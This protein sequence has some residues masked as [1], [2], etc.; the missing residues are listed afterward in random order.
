[1]RMAQPSYA[2]GVLAPSLRSR[3]DLAKWQIGLAEANNMLVHVHGGI[4]NR[5]GTQYV[6]TSLG[7]NRKIPFE[8][9]LDQSY[10]LEFSE[11]KLKIMRD[12]AYLMTSVIDGLEFEAAA[13]YIESPFKN[14]IH[15]PFVRTLS[16][17]IFEYAAPSGNCDIG[18]TGIRLT[19]AGDLYLKTDYSTSSYAYDS[20]INLVVG[21]SYEITLRVYM[22]DAGYAYKHTDFRLTCK[23]LGTGA[24]STMVWVNKA[25]TTFGYVPYY[26]ED[27]VVK[28]NFSTGD[29]F[30]CS[31][32]Y[33]GFAGGWLLPRSDGAFQVEGGGAIAYNREDTENANPMPVVSTGTPYEIELDTPYSESDL[34]EIRYA[35][36]EDVIYLAR[37][38]MA[39]Y[40]LTRRTDLDWALEAVEYAPTI[41]APKNLGHQVNRG[42]PNTVAPSYYV[43]YKV[44]AVDYDGVESVPSGETVAYAWN[45]N[46]WEAG[47]SVS[48]W[49]DEVSGAESYAVYKSSRGY[50]GYIGSCTGT[51]FKDDNIS[52]DSA[53]GPKTLRNPFTS[54]STYPC[55][56]GIYQQRKVYGG[57]AF[58][59]QT[60]HFSNLGTMATFM[61]SRPLKDGDAITAQL[62]GNKING[63]LHYV[64]TKELFALTENGTWSVGPGRNS[65]AITPLNVRFEQQD[66]RGASR[67]PPIVI[68]NTILMVPDYRKGVKELFYSVSD[69]GFR[70]SDLEIMSNHLFKNDQVRDW[71]LQRD[72]SRLWLVMESGTLNI[73]TYLRE[74]DVVA[75]TT[76]DTDGE[77]RSVCSIRGNK[78]DDVYFSVKR[79]INGSY[80]YYTEYISERLPGNSLEDSIFM[81]S[82]LSHDGAPADEFSGL[83]HLEGETVVAL[84]DGNVITG[85][86]VEGGA[87]TLPHEYSKVHIGLPV[88]ADFETLDV[89][90]SLQ[91]GTGFGS[92]KV[93][94]EVVLSLENTRGIKVGPDTD[95]LIEM[96]DRTDEDYDEATNMITG[97]K[98][99]QLRPDWN[100]NG[101]IHVRQDNPLP[102]TILSHIPEVD[103]GEY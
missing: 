36:R 65:D 17:R 18:N 70:G 51:S 67:V 1:M 86:V 85:L 60:A 47:G 11:Y 79:T 3:T 94:N 72:E 84:A 96:K 23:N 78:V 45:S 91:D 100:T 25:G 6:G 63:I 5:P 24:T 52:P 93:I 16:I 64:T 69:G 29:S 90:Y 81:D 12:G 32:L 33:D 30:V 50:Y 71:A 39:E 42:T 92:L 14:Y 34:F 21:E 56:I 74:H 2:A 68:G 75:W 22:Y 83:D 41:E 38:G 76:A 46:Q 4:S 66:S 57:S 95:N 35:Q 88:T 15:P 59:P 103:P 48:V 58:F 20:G 54:V 27:E 28:W 9:S 82:A 101:R 89:D 97:K 10:I 13:D 62:D 31:G 73:L 53:D 37:K 55:A 8:Y 80:V 99:I 49:W 19:T 87:V 44:S 43:S 77:F 26:D 102:V 98:K 40:A 61:V 7:D